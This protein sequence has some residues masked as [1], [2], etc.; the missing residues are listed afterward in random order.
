VYS[1]PDVVSDL[2]KNPLTA[3]VVSDEGVVVALERYE[4]PLPTEN[5]LGEVLR[6]YPRCSVSFLQKGA[7]TVERIG[8]I[9]AE[10][11]EA[12][13]QNREGRLKPGANLFPGKSE[14]R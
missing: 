2:A 10:S 5:L 9:V 14:D 13:R 12:I 11:V 8:E 7:Y 6:R 3:V 4:R 1:I